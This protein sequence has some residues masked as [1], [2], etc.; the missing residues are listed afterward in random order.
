M[1][2]HPIYGEEPFSIDLVGKSRQIVASRDQMVKLS[3][4]TPEMLAAKNAYE[5]L[6]R[7]EKVA[8]RLRHG[9]DVLEWWREEGDRSGEL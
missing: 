8:V 1:S 4:L 2:E 3:A 5:R 7:E 9:G 6:S